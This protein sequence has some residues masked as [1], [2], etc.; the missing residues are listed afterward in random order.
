MILQEQRCAVVS[1]GQDPGIDGPG[2]VRSDREPV[3][4]R[5][6]L[7]DPG[8]DPLALDAPGLHLDDPAKP[9]RRVAQ[10]DRGTQLEC[11]RGKG[12]KLEVAH[13]GILP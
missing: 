8:A 12:H 5:V 7:V 11:Q 6:G 4:V 9:A 2:L 3:G 10:H 1:V 13:G